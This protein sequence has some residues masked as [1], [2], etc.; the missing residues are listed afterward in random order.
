M[1]F[2]AISGAAFLVTGAILTGLEVGPWFLNDFSIPGL[3]SMLI[4]AWLLI[5]THKR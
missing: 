4:G 3:A 2:R 5:R 1:T